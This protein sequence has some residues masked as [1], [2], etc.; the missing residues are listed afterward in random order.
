[1]C[2]IIVY[3]GGKLWEKTKKTERIQIRTTTMAH[4]AMPQ[5]SASADQIDY[6][7]DEEDEDK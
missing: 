3:K 6:Y 1:M 5:S 2:Y 7:D 4:T